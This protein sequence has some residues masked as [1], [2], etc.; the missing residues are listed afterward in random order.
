MSALTPRS[1]PQP[2]SWQHF[3]GWLNGAPLRGI[4]II[5]QFSLQFQLE[6]L[7]LSLIHAIIL[8]MVAIEFT[9]RITIIVGIVI[10][11]VIMHSLR[12]CWGC[13]HAAS[14]SCGHWFYIS[15]F[16]CKFIKILL[17]TLR[18]PSLLRRPPSSCVTSA[19]ITI[20]STLITD[21]DQHRSALTRNIDQHW[22]TLTNNIDHHCA[23]LLNKI[24]QHLPALIKS[25]TGILPRQI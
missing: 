1:N 11:I 7:R 2:T 19:S 8:L 22:S 25:E 4:R 20:L 13:R 17:E 10:M 18:F 15:T 12:V 24:D 3:V 21:I 6:T 16:N 5:F 9:N 14:S 23:A